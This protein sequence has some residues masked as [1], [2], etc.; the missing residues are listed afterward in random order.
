[1]ICVM[2]V[3]MFKVVIGLMGFDVGVLKDVYMFM[4]DFY[5]GYFDWGG[6]LWCELIDL[7]CWMKLLI[8]WYL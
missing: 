5:V 3:L 8:F 7:V 6:V 2:L 4:F 1:M